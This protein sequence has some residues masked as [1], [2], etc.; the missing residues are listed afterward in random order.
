[1]I[2]YT[3]HTTASAVATLSTLLFKLDKS[4][5]SERTDV[6][7]EI[8]KAARALIGEQRTAYLITTIEPYPGD[9]ER[10]L[11][12]AMMPPDDGARRRVA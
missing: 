1:M 7:E 11:M 6:L 5:A 10:D 8:A 12:R 9:A 3:T 4:T 2:P